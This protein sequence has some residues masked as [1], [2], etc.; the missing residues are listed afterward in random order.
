MMTHRTNGKG[1]QEEQDM[2]DAPSWSR[3]GARL[4][5]QEHKIRLVV[6]AVLALFVA[7]AGGSLSHPLAAQLAVLLMIGALLLSRYGLREGRRLRSGEQLHMGAVALAVLDLVAVTLLLTGTGGAQSGFSALYLI[8]LIFAAIFFRGLEVA[9]LTVLAASLYLAVSWSNVFTA[10]QVWH[11]A[12]RLVG[13]AVVS[14]YAYALAAAVRRE[15]GARDQL[16]GHL[17][18]GVMVFDPAERLILANE[19]MVRLLGGRGK[20]EALGT[21]RHALA[22]TGGL[23]GWMV[24]DVGTGEAPGDGSVR[25]GS[26]PEAGLPLVEC[27]TIPCGGDGV[28]D[29]W[30]VVCKDLRAQTVEPRNGRTSSNEKLSPLSSLRTLTQ[31]LYSMAE[32]MDESKRWQAIETIQRHTKALQGIL[33]D[34]LHDTYEAPADGPNLDLSFVEVPALMQ[35]MRRLLEIAQGGQDVPVEIFMADELPDISADRAAIGQSLLQLCKGLL[36]LAGHDDRLVIDVEPSGDYLRFA[37][38]LSSSDEP[39]ELDREGQAMSSAEAS[40]LFVGSEAFAI[41]EE[42]EGRWEC[43]PHD[44]R[45][46]RVVVDLPIAGPHKPELPQ[47]VEQAE[48][49]RELSEIAA[50]SLALDPVLAA[51]VSNQLR[52]SLSVIRGYAEM[53]LKAND[54]ERRQRALELAVNLSDQAAGLVDSL[55]P[56]GGRFPHDEPA[57]SSAAVT[58]APARPLAAAQIPLAGKILVVDDDPFMRQLL[59]DT[60]EDAG[61]ETVSAEDGVK[62]LEYIRA[63]PPAALFVDLSMPG[64]SG[65]DVMREVHQKVPNLPVVLMT[66]YT[67]N[68]AMQALGDEKPYAVIGKPFSINE[69]LSIVNELASGGGAPEGTGPRDAASAGS[70]GPTEPA[71][72]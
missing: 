37:L 25:V 26:F 42:H 20:A 47:T 12:A 6:A 71:R 64:L 11:A 69:V 50:T 36:A 72:S 15:E 45:V 56:A 48:T 43:V 10:D 5:S 51:E 8:S 49:R 41:I 70:G 2:A 59:L 34:M 31:S 19:P 30:V 9:L 58:P 17:T 22:A 67:Y 38:Q 32:Y 29:G 60:L 55:Q 40:E 18:E 54:E 14:W 68:L 23:V 4:L 61:Y 39:V 35:G 53:A 7:V 65:V 44:G 46:R 13:L 28:Q 52:N 3:E 27:A 63:T 57:A 24:A 21:D 62:A 33:A 1:P 16:L 66:G